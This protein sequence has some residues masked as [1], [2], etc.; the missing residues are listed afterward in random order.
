M[1]AC[2]EGESSEC[3]SIRLEFL[4]SDG[5]A[6]SEFS[7][8]ASTSD[9]TVSF[10]CPSGG[11]SSEEYDCNMGGM[12][13]YGFSEAEMITLDVESDSGATFRGDVALNFEE[14]T[15]NDEECDTYREAFQSVTLQGDAGAPSGGSM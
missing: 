14:T 4:D 12:F 9:R 6:L 11:A 5:F 8:S 15:P 2:G 13:L 10:E 7:G 1:V 3:N